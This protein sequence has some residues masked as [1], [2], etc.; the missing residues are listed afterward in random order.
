MT[1]SP[2]WVSAGSV[3]TTAPSWIS[4][5]SPTPISPA[6]VDPLLE[7]RALGADRGVE[8]VAGQHERVGREREQPAVDRLDDRSKSPPSNLVLPGPPGNSV[9]PLKSDRWPSSRKHVEPG[10]WPGVWIV[11]SRRS[12]T[13]ITSSSAITKS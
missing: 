12:P 8:A 11:R 5:R 7:V 10:V 3:R 9:S 1:G 4:G 2:S 13:S 6:P